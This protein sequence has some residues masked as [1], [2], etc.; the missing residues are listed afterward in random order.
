M[1]PLWTTAFQETWDDCR[2]RYVDFKPVGERL[3]E[4]HCQARQ[5]D[6]SESLLQEDHLKT[7]VIA[8]QFPDYFKRVIL[9]VFS[10]NEAT[11]LALDEFAEAMD[12]WHLEDPGVETRIPQW[13]QQLQQQAMHLCKPIQPDFVTLIVSLSLAHLYRSIPAAKPETP[14]G[15]TQSGVCPVCGLPPHFAALVETEGYRQMECWLCGEHWPFTRLECPY[16]GEH[17]PEKLGYFTVEKMEVCRIHF[18]HSCQAYLKVFDTRS[19]ALKD[20]CLWVMHLATLICDDL[21]AA[22][23]YHP[24]SEMEWHQWM[25]ME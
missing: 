3:K 1:H 5:W 17:H 15:A 2:R 23:G 16:C 4:L 14:A 18:C 6:Q 13:L 8:R 11:A 19:L 10:Q 21:A 9:P 20:P 24:G 25:V 12:Q 22:E 7:P